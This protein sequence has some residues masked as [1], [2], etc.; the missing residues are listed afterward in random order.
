MH[1]HALDPAICYSK[2]LSLVLKENV[3]KTFREHL[4]GESAAINNSLPKICDYAMK[5]KRGKK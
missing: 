2:R 3:F 4:N 1:N 5:L